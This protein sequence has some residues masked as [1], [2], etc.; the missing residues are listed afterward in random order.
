MSHITT[1]TKKIFD[2][3][4]PD[5][6]K[7]DIRDIAHA[8]SLLCRANGHFP[9]FHSVAQ[10]SIECAK[11][12]MARSYTARVSLG[13]L[14]HDASEAYLSDI[15][16]PVKKELPRYLVIESE[17][18]NAV[19]CKFLGSPLTKEEDEIVREMD[20]TLLYYEFLTCMNERLSMEQEPLLYTSPTFA[21]EDF[22]AVEM[23]FLSLFSRLSEK[24]KVESRA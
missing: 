2:P 10:H 9:H 21:F 18:Q 5:P 14:L 22:A 16:R 15:T 6:D 8:L 20:D 1:F 13:C 17:L 24:M 12:A 7:L 11:E 19:I 4:N 3:I 23:E